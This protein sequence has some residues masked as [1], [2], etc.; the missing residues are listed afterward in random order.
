MDWDRQ[1]GQMYGP[2]GVPLPMQDFPEPAGEVPGKGGDAGPAP[3]V[4]A[5]QAVQEL[6]LPDPV[7]R[8][9]PD[10]GHAQLVRV[11]TWMWLDRGMWQPV[12]KT[13]SV[14]GVSVTATAIPRTAAW[15]MGDGATVVCAG[16]GTPYVATY[17]ADSASPD[18][19]HTYLRS[20]AGLPGEAYTV[21]V[22]VTWDVEWHGGGRRGVVPGLV[23][24]AQ[25]PLRV[26]EAQAL[27]VS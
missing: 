21:S 26:A 10:Q 4:V 23:T 27:V 16:A 13:V 1:P 25:V 20:S 14:P 9:N 7:I 6:V 3:A 22:S 11:P 24:R 5:Q 15:V 17:A 8:M 18:C 2:R 12:S 19:G